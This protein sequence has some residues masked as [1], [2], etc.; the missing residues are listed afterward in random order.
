MRHVQCRVF[1]EA[2]GKPLV[3]VKVIGHFI[4]DMETR[5][6]ST[7]TF[8]LSGIVGHL[9]CPRVKATLSAPGYS[10]RKQRLT[11]GGQVRLERAARQP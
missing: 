7:G 1:D 3:D 11:S 6:D 5:T 10:T 9:T 4:F 8:E 2:T